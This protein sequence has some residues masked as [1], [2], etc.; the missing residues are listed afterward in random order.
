MF[1][2]NVTFDSFVTTVYVFT[3]RIQIGCVIHRLVYLWSCKYVYL[4]TNLINF[5]FV[6]PCFV[7]DFFK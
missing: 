5:T 2:A 1:S 7:I 4:N 6:L 3:Y